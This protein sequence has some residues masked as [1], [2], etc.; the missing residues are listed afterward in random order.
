[1]SRRPACTLACHPPACRAG[2]E[3][4]SEMNRRTAKRPWTP[5]EDNRLRA[6]LEEGTSTL[7]V[8]AKL[9]RTVTAIKGRAAIIGVSFREDKATA[10]GE[11]EMRMRTPL[12]VA[13]IIG[14]SATAFAQTAAPKVGGKPLRQVKPPA[15]MGCKLVGTVKGT[16]LWAGDCG[17]AS[18]LRGAAPPAVE[19]APPPSPPAPAAGAIPP[20]QKQ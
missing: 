19:V 5:G 12:V 10:E 6:L 8:A 1:M 9:K 3:G 18:E 13:A 7:L 15:P 4:E 11:G 14:L 16:K 20:D 2:A 17:D